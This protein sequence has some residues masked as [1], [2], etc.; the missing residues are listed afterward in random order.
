MPNFLYRRL[1][2]L[3]ASKMLQRTESK[4]GVG[5]CENVPGYSPQ[6]WISQVSF[7][8]PFHFPFVISNQ[9]HHI[10]RF[11]VFSQILMSAIFQATASL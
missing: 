11:E 10:A 8:F 4:G 1:N 6:R 2:V 9:D 5:C 3:C 7:I